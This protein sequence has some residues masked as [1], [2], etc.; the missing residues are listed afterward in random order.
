M[1]AA[2]LFSGIG[3][4]CLGFEQAGISTSWA[5]EVDHHAAETYAH[6]LPQVKLLR[7]DITH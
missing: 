3:G 1:K 6:N 7:K 5:I 2:A 4:F